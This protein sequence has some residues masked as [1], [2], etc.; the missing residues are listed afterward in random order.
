MQITKIYLN[1]TFSK[2]IIVF[3][4]KTVPNEGTTFPSLLMMIMHTDSLY[5]TLRQGQMKDSL[6][7]LL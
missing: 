6:L 7:I 3:F 1:H 4:S 5:N 2:F